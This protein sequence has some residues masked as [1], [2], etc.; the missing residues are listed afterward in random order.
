MRRI[1][2]QVMEKGTAASVRSQ[3]G[4]KETGGGKTGTTNDYKDAW[5]AGY[6]DRVSCGVWV[7]LDKPQTIIDEGYGSRLSIPIWA[8][9]MKKA[10]E[11]GYIPP[12][13]RTEPPVTKVALCRL[14]SQLAA[15]MCQANGTA[16]EDA[17][18][19]ELIPQGFCNSHQDGAAQP[20]QNRRQ[21]RG[22]QGPG[23]WDRVR[24][25]FQ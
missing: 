7:G 15:P 20:T 12:G 11:L 3:H 16:Y 22:P 25:W 17:L 8:D 18:P 10:V 14:S 1:L 24:G 21:P 5:F 4:F 13:P 6:T 2:S 23:L 19:Y 9:V